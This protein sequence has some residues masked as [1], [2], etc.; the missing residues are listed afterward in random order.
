MEHFDEKT[1][2]VGTFACT[3]CGADLKFTPGTTLLKC[4][5]CGNEN[6]IPQTEVQIEELDFHAFLEKKAEE[7]PELTQ[8]FV[9]CDN[10][11]AT[12]T[13]EPHIRSASCPYCSTPL[14]VENAHDEKVIQPR[15]ILPFK[16]TKEQ[17]R[18]Q[19]KKWISKLWFAPN[20]LKKATLNFDHFKGVYI[21]Y[22]TYDTDTQTAYTGQR[23]DH[24]YVTVPYTV[25]ENGKT[26][27]KTRT[28]RRTRWSFTSGSVNEHFDD[29]L[30]VATRSLSEKHI[31]ELEPWD[32]ENLANFERSYLSGFITEKY[33]IGLEEGFDIAKS[34]AKRTIDNS[35]RRQIGGDVQR[36]LTSSTRY[37]N[38]TFKHLLLPVYVS[39]YRFKKKLYQFIVNGRTGEV[40][41]ERPWSIA[42]IAT[43][44]VAILLAAL[45]IYLLV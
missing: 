31:Y 7:Q 13:L 38:I 25:V 19:F 36:I 18:E 4:A 22:W 23:G 29:I 39:A 24:Y 43:L 37:D 26:V 42:K 3:S 11:G 33:Q 10:C 16:L 15:L 35:I 32:M 28:E 12:S 45:G 1:L 20:K 34:I 21:P 14:V 40:Q 30:V 6:E 27:R 8:H 17:A 44:V 2:D 5:H 9:K 41:G